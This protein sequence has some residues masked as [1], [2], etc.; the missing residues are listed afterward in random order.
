[1]ANRFFGLVPWLETLMNLEEGGYTAPAGDDWGGNA[2]QLHPGSFTKV[3]VHPPSVILPVS[4]V[5]V[6]SESHVE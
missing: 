5:Q 3:R 4:P 6:G 1:M 2:A